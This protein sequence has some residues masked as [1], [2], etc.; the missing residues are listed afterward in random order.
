MLWTAAAES[1]HHH[2]TRTESASCSICVVAHSA[3]PTV[4]STYAAPVFAAIGEQRPVA[5]IEIPAP[6][7]LKRVEIA[8]VHRVG[9]VQGV[10][11]AV[12]VGVLERTLEGRAIRLHPVDGLLGA[13]P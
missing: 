8:A 7:E 10:D 9:I 13:V 12:A 6:G 4:S 11:D 3:S 1:T 2:P 5:G